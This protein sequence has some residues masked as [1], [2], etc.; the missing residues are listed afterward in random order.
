MTISFNHTIIAAKDRQESAWF[1]THM[2]GLPGPV[3]AGYFLGVEL[4][5]GVTLDFAQVEEGAEV[6][7]QHYAFLVSEDD[8]DGIYQRIQALKLDHWADP[9]QSSTGFNT[10]DGG[11]GV[12]FLD[13]SGHFPGSDHQAIR[14]LN[15]IELQ[16][17]APT[18][19]E[20]SRRR[21][22]SSRLPTSGPPERLL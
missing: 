12:Y 7:S 11:R 8:F 16:T 10:N 13:P 20:G 9:R 21:R 17:A 19:D 22:R 3:E 14:R 15:Q 18:G 5:H 6:A 1:F 2:F 4:E